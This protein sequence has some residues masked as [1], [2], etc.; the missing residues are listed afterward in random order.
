MGVQAAP[1]TVGAADHKSA[2]ARAEQIKGN[3][4]RALD[5]PLNLAAQR[6]EEP[7]TLREA[8]QGRRKADLE[9]AGL[10][11]EVEVLRRRGDDL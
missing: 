3:T 1:A 6:G 10:R 11:E 2:F 4:Q 9:A 5:Q 7:E 8:E